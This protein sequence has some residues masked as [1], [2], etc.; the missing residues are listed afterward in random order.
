M[1]R[2]TRRARFGISTALA[3][4][5]AAFVLLGGTTL[6]LRAEVFDADSFADRAQSAL[7]HDAIRQTISDELVATAIREG[8]SELIQAKPLLQTV[9]DAALRTPAFNSLFRAAALNL[10]R[11][12][13]D[14]NDRSV[15]LDLADVG[16]VIVGAA[17]AIAPA[18][19]KQIPSDLDARIIDFRKREWAT[20]TLEIADQVRFLGIV[21][22]IVAL[23]LIAASIAIA[24]DRRRGVARV[25]IAITVVAALGF[26]ALLLLRDGL[27]IEGI[28]GDDERATRAVRELFDIFFWDLRAWCLWAGAAGLVLAAAAT[29]ILQP[30]EVASRAERLR[31]LVLRTPTTR[32][33]R[34][35]RGTAIVA[36]SLFVV[37]DPDAFLDVLAIVAGGFGLFFGAS[38]ILSIVTRPEGE[39]AADIATR[40]RQGY[41]FAGV[42]AIVVIGVGVALALILGGTSPTK[43][44]RFGVDANPTY[45]NGFRQLCDRN[46]DRVAFAATHNSMSAGDYRGFYFAHHTGKVREQLDYGFRGLLIDAYY[47]IFDPKRKRVRTDL[48]G[49]AAKKVASALGP[50]GLEAA[51]RLAGRVGLGDLKG[52]KELYLCHALCELGAVKM[53]DVLREVDDFMAAH[54]DEVIVIFIEDYVQPADAARAFKDAGLLRYV[55]FHNRDAPWPTLRQMIT[56]GKRLL[57]LSE[58]KN[59]LGRFP[60]YEKGFDLTQDTPYSFKNVDQIK[61]FKTSCE[62]LRGNTNS[63][64]FL[65]NHWIERVNPSPGQT[66]EVNGFG[67]LL[68]RA[69]ACE[70]VRGLSPPTLVAVNFYDEGD[71]LGVV[72]VLNGIPR[73]AKQQLPTRKGA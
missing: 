56:S 8:T 36:V 15:A 14:R 32:W 60:W 30:V 64:L 33:G 19:A 42:T 25:G 39:T 44:P 67:L 40:R 16:Q 18:V 48:S 3:I 57:V 49:P 22:P 5:A 41:V 45:C 10:H 53:T 21:L 34:V 47:G 35:G 72:N 58:N 9:V 7:K 73:N 1:G 66:R 55:L 71:T 46:L 24:P 29:S 50:Q 70:R 68:R 31:R 51:Q 69:Q 23:L 52:K 20:T 27:H 63:P 6:Y 61:D 2:W 4:V 38:E 11:L 26:I 12:A 28:G 59:D 37:L 62:L 17:R 43:R 65:L 13:F 54:P